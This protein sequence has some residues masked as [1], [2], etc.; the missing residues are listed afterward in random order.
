ML[1]PIG[2]DFSRIPFEEGNLAVDSPSIP[3]IPAHHINFLL[4]GPVER[5]G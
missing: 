5:L 4:V 2:I 1:S 3:Q